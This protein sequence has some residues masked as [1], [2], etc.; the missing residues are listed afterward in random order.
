V[1]RADLETITKRTVGV[2]DAANYLGVHPRTVQ[3]Y[4]DK[5]YIT[6]ETLP[7]GYRRL[8]RTSVIA[9]KQANESRAHAS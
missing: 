4:C 1:T 7:S 9:F 3:R 8:H 5:G 2:A 6:C